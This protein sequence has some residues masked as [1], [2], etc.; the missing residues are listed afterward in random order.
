MKKILIILGTLLSIICLNGC[1][2][3]QVQIEFIL[4]ETFYIIQINRKSIIDNDIVPIDIDNTNYELYYDKDFTQQ[5]LNE[6]IMKNTTL[7]IDIQKDNKTF[8]SEGIELFIKKCYLNWLNKRHYNTTLDDINVKK[9]IGCYEGIHIA[10]I[11]DDIRTIQL[12]PTLFDYRYYLCIITTPKDCFM[13]T[14]ERLPEVISVYYD[15]Q[16]F[17]LYKACEEGFI[18]E[19]F[20]NKLCNFLY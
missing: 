13:Y 10:V 16:Y 1:K 9:Y 18:T 5:Y 4:N 2:K 11:E 3:E 12:T 20:M 17:E 14:M 15:N 6:P 8:M 7:Y 19:D